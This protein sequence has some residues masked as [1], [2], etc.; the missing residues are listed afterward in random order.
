MIDIFIPYWG[1][2]Q[3]LYA[4]VGSVLA[5]TS[6]SW[7][8]TVVDDCYPEDVSEYFRR[9]DDPR[10]RYIRNDENLGIIDNFAKCQAMAEGDYTVIMGC[11]DLM[12]PDYASTIERVADRNPGVEI[13]QPGVRVVDA[14]GSIVSPL[15][16]RVKAAIRPRSKGTGVIS[17]EGLARSLLVG[18]WLYWPSLAFRTDVFKSAKFDPD[19]Q[20]ILDL[21]LVLDLV[22]AGA[23]LALV[24]DEVFFYRRHEDSLSSQALLDGPRFADERKFFLERA[25]AMKALG[26]SRA[27][28]MASLHPT[29]RLHALAMLPDAIRNR[30]GIRALLQ[31]AFG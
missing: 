11:D 19:Y 18:D 2:P 7:R 14:A 22:Q 29:S 21:G 26:W 4:A 9:I 6:D 27:A 24:D 17:G 12:H 25:Q 20:I 30:K 3:S 8:L 28:R 5:Q 1:D 31:H 13:I 16:D 15:A 23:R 10:V